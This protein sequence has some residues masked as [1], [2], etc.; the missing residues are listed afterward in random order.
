MA[1]VELT[2]A[3]KIQILTLAYNGMSQFEIK[4]ETG[5]KD[6]RQ[7]AGV[8]SSQHTPT[9]L[10]LLKKAGLP[11]PFKPPPKM[12]RDL[13]EPEEKLVPAASEPKDMPLSALMPQAAPAP[14]PVANGGNIDPL[15]RV[16][17]PRVPGSPAISTAPMALG[18]SRDGT[19]EKYFVHR[20]SPW[21]AL[22]GTFSPPFSIDVVGAKFG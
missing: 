2:E 22:E 9:G 15:P 4:K 8:I 11:G 19:T 14:A 12:R 10:Y 21:Q 16:L 17:G 1:K 20:E 3:Q 5:I 7:I 6:G 13:T 18:F